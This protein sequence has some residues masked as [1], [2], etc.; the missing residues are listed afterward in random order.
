[1]ESREDSAP[2]LLK[3]NGCRQNIS[4]LALY[5]LEEKTRRDVAKQLGWPEGTVATRLRR[6]RELLRKRLLRQGVA[7]S[8]TGVGLALSEQIA[9]AAASDSLV[10]NTIQSALAVVTPGAAAGLISANAVRLANEL[11]PVALLT[12]IRVVG[13]LLLAAMAGAGGVLGFGLVKSP[14]RLGEFEPSPSTTHVR[15]E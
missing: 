12:P 4:A 6:G 8:A 13:V 7:Y 1:M 10:V 9:P 5:Y 3:S 15:H 2:T 11:A 14:R